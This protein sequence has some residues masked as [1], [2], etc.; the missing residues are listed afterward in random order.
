MSFELPSSFSLGTSFVQNTTPTPQRTAPPPQSQQ[1]QKSVAG[2]KRNIN[3]ILTDDNYSHALGGDDDDDDDENKSDITQKS[4][5]DEQDEEQT[6][7]RKRGRPRKNAAQPNKPESK[8]KKKK[9]SQTK[10]VNEQDAEDGGDEVDD[11][12][13][14]DDDQD[15]RQDTNQDNDL[16]PFAAL[17]REDKTSSIPDNKRQS[18]RE[19]TARLLQKFTTDQQKRYEAFKRSKFQFSAIKKVMFQAS[20]VASNHTM[21]IVMAGITKL[22]VGD[23]VENAKLIM[24]EWNEK[25][26]VQPKHLKEAYRR[27]QQKQGVKLNFRY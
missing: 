9:D 24:T 8:R 4:D 20:N 17:D 21:Q 19:R 10:A 1:A 2:K 22:Y 25:G 3:E 6:T 16:D 5:E 13:D 11:N 12:Q 7:K 23:L 18:E 15:N 27:I 26:P 14:N